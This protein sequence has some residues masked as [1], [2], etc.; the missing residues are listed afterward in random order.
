MEQSPEYMRTGMLPA[1]AITGWCHMGMYI[2]EELLRKALHI[3]AGQYITNIT[4]NKS[5]CLKVTF[6]NMAL[7][8]RNDLA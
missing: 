3:S 1:A 5:L 7:L 2:S 8:L 4:Q 6:C